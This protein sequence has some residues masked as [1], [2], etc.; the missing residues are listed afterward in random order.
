MTAATA[1]EYT[2]HKRAKMHKVSDAIRIFAVYYVRFV[3]L[4]SLTAVELRDTAMDVC[5]D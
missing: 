1:P 5:Y 3:P 2:I 4:F